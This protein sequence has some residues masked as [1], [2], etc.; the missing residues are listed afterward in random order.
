LLGISEVGE[1]GFEGANPLDDPAFDES[2]LFSGDDPG[3]Q[4]ERE[5]SFFTR[6]AERDALVAE[7]ALEGCR[8][9]CEVSDRQLRQSLMHSAG[10]L[11]RHVQ[12]REDF[13][14]AAAM[15]VAVEEVAHGADARRA[16]FP[17][18]CRHVI[19]SC[20]RGQPSPPRR[21]IERTIRRGLVA[22]AFAAIAQQAHVGLGRL[23]TDG[24]C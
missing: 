15:S 22:P 8:P 4:I 23:W 5:R 14:P 2:P 18:C 9:V 3:N 12:V 7:G 21:P 13:I 19:R 17:S 24:A 20:V 16:S 10:C 11:V 6:Q 1:Q